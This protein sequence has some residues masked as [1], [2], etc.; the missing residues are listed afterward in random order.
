MRLAS[1]LRRLTLFGAPFLVLLVNGSAFAVGTRSI[2]Q[3]P[4]SE[5]RESS[6]APAVGTVSPLRAGRPAVLAPPPAAEAPSPVA[7]PVPPPLPVPVTGDPLASAA[8]PLTSPPQ[9]SPPAAPPAAAASSE[10]ATAVSARPA[11]APASP[12]PRRPAQEPAA[13]DDTSLEQRRGEA[14]LADIHFPWVSTGYEIVFLPGNPDYEALTISASRRIEVYVSS[15]DTHRELV[16]T[17][18]HEIGHAVDLTFGTALRRSEYRRI[19]GLEEG[20]DWFPCWRCS[21]F[22][23]PAG[24]FAETFAYWL[25]GPGSFRS[26]LAP[27]PSKPQLDQLAPLFQPR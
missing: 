9:T 14:A 18:A 16:F 17:L 13:S 15:S 10:P 27:P 12:T 19:R 21:D 8:S 6:M 22:A 25:L 3:P 4:A 7:E 1:T 24:D 26:R 23:A 20:T 5:R 11:T 2:E